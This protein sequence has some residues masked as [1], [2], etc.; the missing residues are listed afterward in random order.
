MTSYCD[1]TKDVHTITI[2][3][4]GHCTILEFGKGAYNEAVAQGITRPLHATQLRNRIAGVVD[5]VILA[6]CGKTAV[7][8]KPDRKP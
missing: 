6:A 7:G 5:E 8:H 1:V 2:T 4:I 3:T